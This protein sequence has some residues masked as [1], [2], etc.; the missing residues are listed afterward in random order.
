MSKTSARSSVKAADL[1]PEAYDEGSDS[2]AESEDSEQ[3][4]EDVVDDLKYDVRNMTAYN[5]S[6]LLLPS[7]EH[8]KEAFIKDEATRATQL[9]INRIFALPMVATDTGPLATL[10][11]EETTN[12]PRAQHLP[13]AKTATKW[14]KFAQEKGIKNRK[15]ERM[16]Y[17]E[18]EGEYRPRYGYKRANNGIMDA[19]VVEIKKNDDPFADPWS[20]AR[21]EKKERIA[22]NQKQQAKNQERAEYGKVLKKQ[23]GPQVNAATFGRP[24]GIPVNIGDARS[25]K[26][27][28]MKRGKEGVSAA[29]QLA[30]HSTAS[31]GRYDEAR[32]GEPLI[33]L[34]GKKRSFRD[35]SES[36]STSDHAAMK[37]NI[38]IVADKADKKAKGVTNSLKA[39]EGIIPDAPAD[40]FKQTK[41]KGKAR[42]GGK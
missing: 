8:E 28:A 18:L 15:R 12:L 42:K 40:T 29:L 7:K 6:A 17:D 33:K 19:P 5:Y 11:E 35:N 27:G 24:A 23:N 34:K 9:I 32:K 25:H 13:E 16:V 3:R 41:G 1:V 31:M 38:R 39:Y 22:K 20:E 21:S 2:D 14:E 36:V 10:P 37:A 30:Q 26:K 4:Q